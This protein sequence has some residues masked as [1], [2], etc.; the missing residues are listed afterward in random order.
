M[1]RRMVKVK[2]MMKKGRNKRSRVWR[3]RAFRAR[4]SRQT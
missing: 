2:D 3:M 1:N 4:R